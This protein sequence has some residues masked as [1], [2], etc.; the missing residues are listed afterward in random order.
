MQQ[1]DN[2]I[3]LFREKGWTFSK[4]AS[5]F[6]ISVERARQICLMEDNTK[7]PGELK[8]EIERQY[9]ERLVSKMDYQWL[10]SEIKTLAK[11]DRTQQNV[12]RR[13]MLIT[14]L[15]DKMFFSFFSIARLLNRHHT[16]IKSLYD[17]EII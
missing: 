11:R 3:R 2:S 9:K 4:L 1:R 17:I 15:H 13:Q 12:I 16:S 10:Q 5:K 7:K 6:D 14:Y 8:K